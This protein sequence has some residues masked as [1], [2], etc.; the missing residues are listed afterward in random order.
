MSGAICPLHQHQ[1]PWC[2]RVKGQT[3]VPQPLQHRAAA[4][5]LV[6]VLAP[7]HGILRALPTVPSPLGTL[8]TSGM[9]FRVL[10]LVFHWGSA[11]VLT[12]SVGDQ[13]L[14]SPWFRQ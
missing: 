8:L 7:P 11:S 12:R 13:G 1:A 4:H 5:C 14:Q 6:P 3:E 10:P 9:S 2:C